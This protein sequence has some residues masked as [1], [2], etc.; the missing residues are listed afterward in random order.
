VTY[1]GSS[2]LVT[3]VVERQHASAR[4]RFLDHHSTTLTGTST[5][6]LV[7]TIRTRGRL[8]SYPNLMSRLRCEHKE[9]SVTDAVR[10]IA[11]RA[12]SRPAAGVAG[13]DAGHGVTEFERH[14]G[15][16]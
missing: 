13:R 9:I 1:L 11:A 15:I 10:D 14:V 6:G 4:L 2:A 3:M 16:T 8:G 12:G 5:F 7:E